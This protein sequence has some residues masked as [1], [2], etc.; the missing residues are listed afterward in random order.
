VRKTVDL[1]AN[2][3][4]LTVIV[5]GRVDV[6]PPVLALFPWYERFGADEVSS[7]LQHFGDELI[8]AYEY[9]CFTP[10][11]LRDALLRWTE[12]DSDADLVLHI[13]AFEHRGDRSSCQ[14]CSGC[15]AFSTPRTPCTCSI[16]G[17]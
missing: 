16:S 7:R 15:N 4:F 13:T 3:T 17:G 5:R 1:E 11:Q 12:A 6:I 10:F 9:L 14:F 2:A 8:V